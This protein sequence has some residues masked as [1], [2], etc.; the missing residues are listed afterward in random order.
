DAANDLLIEIEEMRFGIHELG[1]E[2]QASS[3]FW[4]ILLITS[5]SERS[6]PDPLLRRC[7]FHHIEFP[8]NSRLV[9]IVV[10]RISSLG[11]GQELGQ[12]IITKGSP[13]LDDAI[14]RF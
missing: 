12:I 7:L 4:P 9:Q 13:M 1:I 10:D 6:F 5:N 14:T 11:R 8:D 3:K 2:I